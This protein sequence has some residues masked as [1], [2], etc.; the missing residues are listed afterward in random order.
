MKKVFIPL[1]ALVCSIAFAQT[2]IRA[3]VQAKGPDGFF[4]PVIPNNLVLTIKNQI[5]AELKAYMATN[6]S[7]TV[8][9]VINSQEFN[10]A[11]SNSCTTIVTPEM[12]QEIVGT[13]TISEAQAATIIND[14]HEIKIDNEQFKAGFGFITNVNVTT[15]MSVEELK[16]ALI[17]IIGGMQKALGGETNVV[18]HVAEP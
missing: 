8:E 18:I 13:N 7:I 5:L 4:G 12:I 15:D 11:V 16:G 17:T 6:Q 9:D 3:T 2:P 14:T 1:I 10:T